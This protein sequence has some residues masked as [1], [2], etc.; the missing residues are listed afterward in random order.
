VEIGNK[1]DTQVGEKIGEYSDKVSIQNRLGM[2]DDRVTAAEEEADFILKDESDLSERIYRVHTLQNLNGT[3]R[4]YAVFYIL[5]KDIADK[6]DKGITVKQR[7]SYI[8]GHVAG[9]KNGIEV[10]M[11]ALAILMAIVFGL[12][13]FL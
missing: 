6:L 4:Y 2:S 3:E 12:V 5:Q 9:F 11:V 10:G 7:K 1:N 13:I 8:E